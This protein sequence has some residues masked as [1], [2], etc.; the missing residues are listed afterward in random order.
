MPWLP[1]VWAWCLEE[2][3]PMQGGYGVQCSNKRTMDPDT[4]EKVQL[5]TFKKAT[6]N[7]QGTN[8]SLLSNHALWRHG[9]V[10]FIQTAPSLFILRTHE[11]ETRASA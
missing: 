6:T 3:E 7:Q 5:R 2:V 11:I 4:C 9:F 8:S 1:F 10:G